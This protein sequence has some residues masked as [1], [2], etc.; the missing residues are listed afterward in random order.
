MDLK[1]KILVVN[2]DRKELLQ[3]ERGLEELGAEP[4]CLA[5]NRDA[6]RI[7]NQEK[8]DGIFLSYCASGMRAAVLA[9][10][11]RE[12]ESNGTCPVVLVTPMGDSIALEEGL[13]A[14]INFFLERP[15][16]R[17]R[18]REFWQA[19]RGVSL[20]ERRDY[21]RVPVA[22]TKILCCWPGNKMRGRIVNMSSKGLLMALDKAP[23]VK[24]KIK[25]EFSLS[26]C[27]EGFDLFAKVIRVKPGDESDQH[28]AIRFLQPADNLRDYLVDLM[29][30]AAAG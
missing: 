28:V 29:G 4:Y 13:R 19:V 27:P 5:S 18:L 12:S 26:G 30:Q 8:Y 10:K 9:E 25:V 3:L 1:P 2:E 20:E 11:I 17:E 24:Q 23:P 21:E 6:A 7:I 22:K 15:F 14:G 16:E